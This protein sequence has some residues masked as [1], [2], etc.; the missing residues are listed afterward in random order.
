[1]FPFEKVSLY[2]GFFVSQHFLLFTCAATNRPTYVAFRMTGVEDRHLALAIIPFQVK[3][4][5]SLFFLRL[6]TYVKKLVSFRFCRI[7]NSLNTGKTV[8]S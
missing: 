2:S 6:Q 4:N 7:F 1:M 5:N 8:D 3:V